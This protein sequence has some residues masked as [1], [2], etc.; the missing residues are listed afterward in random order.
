MTQPAPAS[1]LTTPWSSGDTKCRI[2]K[3]LDR[4][5]RR[6]LRER[7]RVLVLTIEDRSRRTHER[8]VVRRDDLRELARPER[9]D[10]GLEVVGRVRAGSSS[11][12]R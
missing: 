5:A 3:I 4:D 10:A 11:S 7:V 8:V 12:G 2:S 6:V 1:W 9:V